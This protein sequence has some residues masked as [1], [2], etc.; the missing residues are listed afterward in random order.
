MTRRNALY[1][2][3]KMAMAYDSTPNDALL[4][5]TV[6]TLKEKWQPVQN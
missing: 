2:T 1:N 4:V 3:F 5:I 6:G